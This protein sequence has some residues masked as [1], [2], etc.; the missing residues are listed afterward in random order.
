MDATTLKPDN[1]PAGEVQEFN[2]G[3][4][5]PER[6]LK[7]SPS[8]K[9]RVA[10][11]TALT[12]DRNN[13]P[14]RDW[15]SALDLVNEAFEAIRIAEER[16]AAAEEYHQQL[17]VHHGEQMRA[18]EARLMATERRAEAAEGRAKEAE[19]WLAKFHDTIVDGF[20]R[21]FITK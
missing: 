6:V 16:A 5:G 13:P 9:D 1:K 18:L 17:V 19:G 20:Q 21:T 3:P 15:S 12:G 7:F 11:L 8:F 4:D 2:D 10:P 14:K